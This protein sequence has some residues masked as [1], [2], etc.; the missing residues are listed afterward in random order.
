MPCLGTTFG[1]A[2][3]GRWDPFVKATLGGIQRQ[4]YKNSSIEELYLCIK[5]VENSLRTGLGLFR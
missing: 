4:L 5:R 2:A 1:G 3:T